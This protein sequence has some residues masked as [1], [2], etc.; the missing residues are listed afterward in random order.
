MGRHVSYQ[1]KITEKR[2]L[3]SG[4]DYIPW[5]KVG[6]SHDS[7]K[8]GEKSRGNEFK[9]KGLKTKRTHHLL[10]NYEKL[11]FI[12][13]DLNPQISDIREQFPLLD[14]D[15]ARSISEELG[16]KYP[17]FQNS[18]HILTSDF[19]IDFKSGTS[20]IVTFKPLGN[21]DSRQLELFQIEKTYWQRKG[22][23]WHIMTEL[24]IPHEPIWL[25][26]YRD[27]YESINLFVSG[28]ISIEPIQL[29]YHFLH[30][31]FQDLGQ[32]GVVSFMKTAD[33]KLNFEEGMSLR[34]FKILI[35]RRIV[36][37]DLRMN[38][39]SNEVL[40]SSIKLSDNVRYIDKSNLVA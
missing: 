29:F 38:T 1:R 19:W 20:R 24:D 22:I 5:Y 27:I 26:N 11:L 9:L 21:I 7:S 31:S 28:D 8:R 32:L 30:M 37:A 18:Q 17:K 16:I 10:S 33:K 25:S 12:V 13:F 23:E 2:G 4:K 14:T 15:L 3:G 34:I 6:E 36:N 40:L 39:F 35:A